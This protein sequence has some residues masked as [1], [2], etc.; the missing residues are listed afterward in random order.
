MT[1][2]LKHYHFNDLVDVYTRTED[3]GIEYH[4][5]PMKWGYMTWV[6]LWGRVGAKNFFKG[7]TTQE[8]DSKAYVAILE[9]FEEI[10]KQIQSSIE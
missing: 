7:S 4:I 10:K 1:Y 5:R 8:G 2:E 6:S 3:T 9:W